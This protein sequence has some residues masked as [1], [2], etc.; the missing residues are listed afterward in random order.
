MAHYWAQGIDTPDIPREVLEEYNNH[1]VDLSWEVYQAQLS[2]PRM[3]PELHK[4]I[5]L[6][7]AD[8]LVLQK[9]EFNGLKYDSERS[10]VEAA[11]LREELS[12]I[13]GFLLDLTNCPDFN[14]DSGD[15]L[16][17][18]LYGGYIEFER[19]ETVDLVYKSGPRKGEEYTRNKFI[20][21]DKYEYPGYFKPLKGSELAKSTDERPYYS[22]AEPILKQ[23][24]ARSRVQ[25]RIIESLLR[26]AELTKLIET[27]FVKL[28]ELIEVMEW[29]DGIVHGQYNQVVARTGRL[30]SSRPNMQNNPS[31]VDR[32]FV[33][34]Y[35]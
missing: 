22:S 3:T 23:L 7:G 28:P 11:K 29:S 16:S 34:R 19:Y 9:M 15:H 2:D 14:F 35:A 10:M 6:D 5:L 25:K 17:A 13:D 30:S 21:T 8:L 12:Q 1:D 18:F 26:R 24:S 32:M 27:Y 31:E 20:R 33:S 4:L